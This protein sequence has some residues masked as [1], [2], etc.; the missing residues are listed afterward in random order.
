[1]DSNFYLFTGMAGI[2]VGIVLGIVAFVYFRRFKRLNDLMKSE[3]EMSATAGGSISKVEEVRRSNS[4][5]IWTNEYPV[6]TYTVDG[7]P[8]TASLKYAEKRSGYY[9]LGGNYSVHYKPSD[10]SC[11]LVEEFRK[12]MKS[13]GTQAVI[14]AAVLAI[15]TLNVF[16]N[17]VSTII[18]VLT[19]A[20]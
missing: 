19:G 13:Y 7:K 3:P 16:S 17:G 14:V 20:I 6:I 15:F 12:Q 9:S 11:C 5:F 1:M 8:Y 10:P 2:V 4:S 18:K